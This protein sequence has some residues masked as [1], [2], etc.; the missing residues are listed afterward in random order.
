MDRLSAEATKQ[1]RRNGLGTAAVSPPRRRVASAPRK[2]EQFHFPENRGNRDSFIF[3]ENRDSFIFPGPVRP[4]GN[5]TVPVFF[6]GTPPPGGGEENQT[7]PVN[8]IDGSMTPY[9]DFA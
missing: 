3:P 4:F 5:V 7:V 1:A 6:G 8:E 2:P 9:I